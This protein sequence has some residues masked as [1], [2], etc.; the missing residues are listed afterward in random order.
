MEEILK[1]INELPVEQL[2]SITSLI[3]KMIEPRVKSANSE[4]KLEKV[5]DLK[6][7]S[8]NGRSIIVQHSKYGYNIYNTTVGKSGKLIKGDLIEAD[9]SSDIWNIRNRFRMNR[10]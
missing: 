4:V 1:L 8:Y 7:L 10:I 2:Q 5:R 3:D 6:W 9:S